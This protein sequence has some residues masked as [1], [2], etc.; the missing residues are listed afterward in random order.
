MEKTQVDATITTRCRLQ[1]VHDVWEKLDTN[2]QKKLRESCFGSLL[3]L[4]D[5]RLASQIIHQ[6]LLRKLKTGKKEEV[7]FKIG[8]KRTRFGLEEF[9]LVTGFIAGNDDNVDETLGAE[10][11]ILKEYFKKSVGKITKGDAYNAFICC[12]KRKSDKYKLGLVVILAYVLWAKEENTFIELWW[13]DLVDDLDRFEK[14]PWGKFSFEYTM[15]VFKREMGGK[16]KILDVKGESR[17]RYS[18]HGFPLA[19]MV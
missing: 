15:N 18:L 16:L 12:K 6:L 7:W 14:Y 19:I 9:V 3:R 8:G 17:C 13:L 1:I 5:I 2:Y 11:R 10:C 4:R